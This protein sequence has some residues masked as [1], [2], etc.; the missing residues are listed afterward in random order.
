MNFSAKQSNPKVSAGFEAP[1]NI[2]TR[3]AL[4][5]E[6]ELTSNVE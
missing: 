6:K 2:Y 3:A 5:D 1:S 4:H